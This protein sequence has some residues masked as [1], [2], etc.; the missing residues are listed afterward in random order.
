MLRNKR[1]IAESAATL[2][3]A[4]SRMNADSNTRNKHIKLK[5]MKEKLEEFNIMIETI[6][7]NK[8]FS[9][10]INKRS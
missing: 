2:E 8:R 3:M 1:C 5:N 7:E 10:D 6:T 4:H 9:L